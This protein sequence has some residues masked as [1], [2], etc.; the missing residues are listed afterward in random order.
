M[1]HYR[2]ALFEKLALSKALGHNY[3]QIILA[4]TEI[5][6]KFQLQSFFKPGITFVRQSTIHIKLDSLLKTSWMQKEY[7]AIS[8]RE[9]QSFA[10]LKECRHFSMFQQ[11]PNSIWPW[12][13]RAELPFDAS[14]LSTHPVNLGIQFWRKGIRGRAMVEWGWK[15]RKVAP[16]A[17]LSHQLT[18]QAAAAAAHNT[19]ARPW[20]SEQIAYWGRRQAGLVEVSNRKK[21]IRATLWEENLPLG[22]SLKIIHSQQQ[23]LC[24]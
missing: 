4:E 1:W 20:K 13:L 24:V 10:S 16:R 19:P 3:V 9:C 18:P 15:E 22:C 14:L 5:F 7:R 21:L 12:W 2:V 8:K 6:S 17:C 11:N 23:S